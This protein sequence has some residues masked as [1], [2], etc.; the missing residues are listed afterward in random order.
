[1]LLS[2]FWLRRIVRGMLVPNCVSSASLALDGMASSVAFVCLFGIVG[3]ACVFV[4]K[5]DGVLRY[6]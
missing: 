1:M 3:R 4:L 5:V 2:G 6:V